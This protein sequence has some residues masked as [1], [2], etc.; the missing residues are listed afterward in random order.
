MMEDNKPKSIFNVLKVLVI[1]LGFIAL[2]MVLAC[3]FVS[4]STET[5]LNT[6]NYNTGQ[7][8][9]KPDLQI[10]SDAGAYDPSAGSELYA[11]SEPGISIPGWGEIRILANATDISS[12]DFYNPEENELYYL[13]FELRLPDSSAQGY[14]V[15]YKSGLVEP[16][17]H[18]QHISLS[19]GI[20]EGEYNVV[21]FVQPYRISDKS[22]TN[23][24]EI[25]T[26]LLVIEK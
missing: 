13:T 12:V 25:P 14:E 4:K 6:Y 9:I 21:V 15:L 2:L 18:I 3:V 19:R 17:K 7:P 20:P 11:D 22:P 10:D 5:T 23:C 1:V 16:G 26:K 24:A 8:P